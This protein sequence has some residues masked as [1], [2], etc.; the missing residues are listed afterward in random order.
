MPDRDDQPTPSRERERTAGDALPTPEGGAL[1]P[2]PAGEDASD[3]DEQAAAGPTGPMLLILR[4]GDEEYGIPVEQ[5]R[6]VIEAPQVT[7]VPLAPKH[8]AGVAAVRGDII[9]VVDLGERLQARPTVEAHRMVTVEAGDLGRVG[10]LADDV[11]GMIQASSAEAIDPVPP[12]A[13]G[14]LPPDV[15]SGVYAPSDGRMVV[16]LNLGPLLAIDLAAKER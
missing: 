7:R 15:A 11:I 3:P 8:V 13:A 2:L 14:S 9:P 16:L 6:E 5:V 1:P 10:V 4:C 12:D